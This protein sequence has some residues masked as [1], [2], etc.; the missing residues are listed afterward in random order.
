MIKNIIFR[1]V[2]AKDAEEY[3]KLVDFVWRDAYKDIFPEEVFLDRE[4]HFEEK[5]KNFDKIF[6]NDNIVFTYVVEYNNKI[7]GTLW[8]TMNSDYLYFKEKGYAD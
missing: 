7:I 1:K 8:G 5:L 4:S 3:I 2:N 6:Y